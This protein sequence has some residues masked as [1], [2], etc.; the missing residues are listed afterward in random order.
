MKSSKMLRSVYKN[1]AD[2]VE[3][4][5][6]RGRSQ[7]NVVVA[8]ANE[9]TYA[10]SEYHYC[11]AAIGH[12]NC[13]KPKAVFSQYQ[14][15]MVD[16]SIIRL[17]YEWL[18]N[19]SPFSE[20]FITKSPRRVFYDSVIVTRTDLPGNFIGGALISSRLPTEKHSPQY[21]IC[22]SVIIWDR[23]VKLGVHPNMAFVLACT[24]RPVSVSKKGVGL[25]I[26]NINEVAFNIEY[27]GHYPIQTQGYISGIDG[28]GVPESTYKNFFLGKQVNPSKH[29]IEERRDINYSSYL[30]TDLVNSTKSY[31]I[32]SDLQKLL[33]SELSGAKSTLNPF[34][35]SGYSDRTKLFAF[36]PAM[37]VIAKQAKELVKEWA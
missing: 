37:E 34:V 4:V 17:Y 25:G 32:N 1:Y 24:L 22:G 15:P 16:E 29:T 9:K 27:T 26:D 8:L 2:F 31:T 19:H 7:K 14:L 33:I 28:S 18:F 5:D 12:A 20:A 10:V 11:H 13:I 6:D 35:N 3:G 23:L 21:N 36:N 30:W